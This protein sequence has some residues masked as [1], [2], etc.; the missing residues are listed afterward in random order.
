[1]PKNPL[2]ILTREHEDNIPLIE[3]LNEMGMDTLEYPCIST[4]ITPYT[5]GEICAGKSLKDFRVVAF[6]SKRGVAGMRERREELA[7]S[8]QLL[9]AVGKVTAQEV[10]K[11]IGRKP[12]VVAHPQTGEG[13]ARSVLAKLDKPAPVLHV[14][15]GKTS[16]TFRQALEEHGFEVC[17]LIVYENVAPEVKPLELEGPAVA[18]FASPSAAQC[19]FE[20]NPGLSDQVYCVAIGPI[21]AQYLESRNLKLVEVAFRPD[22]DHL[23]ESIK[24]ILKRGFGQ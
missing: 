15:G 14:R 12:D 8:D 24:Q 19:F 21:T 9:A 10:E 5:G 11:V 17:E 7:G 2:I 6:T 13:L 18:V 23:V 20:C 3:R 22:T 16:G 1:M 4:R